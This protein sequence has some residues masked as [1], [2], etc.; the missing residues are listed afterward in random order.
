M[1][2]R[3]RRH[4]LA[5]LAAL[6]SYAAAPLAA[7]TAPVVHVASLKELPAPLPYPYDSSAD[8]GAQVAAG[9]AAAAAAG[10][11]LL[12]DLGGNWCPDCRVLAGVMRLPAVQGFV[13]AH[14]VVVPVDVGRMDKNLDV[15]K[16]FGVSGPIR[17]GP[18]VVVTQPTT[19]MALNHG[20]IARLSC[21]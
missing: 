11:L 5:V 21:T 15:R 16:R 20:H 13:D 17:S 19:H 8:A 3:M 18:S 14:Y 2:D 7:A 12:I 6:V 4:Y 10:K 9:E 1:E